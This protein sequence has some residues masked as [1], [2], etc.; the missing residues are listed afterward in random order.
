M[1]TSSNYFDILFFYYCKF[2]FFEK[3]THDFLIDFPV[4]N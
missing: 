3:F 1:E 2:N 4:K